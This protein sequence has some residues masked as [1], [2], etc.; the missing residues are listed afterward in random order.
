[1][2]RNWLSRG[3]HHAEIHKALT[4]K[5]LQFRVRYQQGELRASAF[6]SFIIDDVVMGH[7]LRDDVRIL[8][9]N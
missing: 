3:I 6:Y 7:M 2:R 1:L 5:V 9:R 8:R 4:A